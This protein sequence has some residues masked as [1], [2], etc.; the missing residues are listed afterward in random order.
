MKKMAAILVGFCCY[1]MSLA[2][3]RPIDRIVA[4]VNDG[5]ITQSQVDDRMRVVKLNLS[6][7][8]TPLPSDDILAQQI[9]QQLINI[10]LQLDLAKQ[11]GI[12]V[13]DG[14]VSQTI[15]DIAQNNQ[16]SV[17]N[18]YQSITSRG[19]DY[20]KFRKE[21]AE[22]LTL[23]HL[24]QR[25]IAARITVSDQEVD[26][27]LRSEA[28]KAANDSEYRVENILIALPETPNPDAI[29]KAQALA[30]K[31]LADVHDGKDFRA[32]AVVNSN[33]EQA[34]QGGDLGFRKL[35]QLPTA[36]A[37]EITHMKV[38][39]VVGPI[40]TGNGFHLIKLAE[41]RTV[42]AVDK[43]EV[44]EYQIQQI[45]LKIDARQSTT[46]IKA[47]LQEIR[48]LALM[49]NN[50]SSLAKTNTQDD[51]GGESRWV[52][53][54]DLPPIFVEAIARLSPNDISL[55]FT[56]GN[57]VYLVRLLDK[58]FIEKTEQ[59]IAETKELIFQRKFEESIQNWLVQ[60]RQ[61]SYINIISQNPIIATSSS[62]ENGLPETAT[63]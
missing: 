2:D 33:A 53:P 17:E 34:L 43:P 27:Y 25:D 11:T 23:R 58:H 52:N 61:N 32:L 62:T 30:E 29:K 54:S 9:L 7:S 39:D 42:G 63:T 35:A 40:R 31:L 36:F 26:D 12:R 20:E 47:R 51:Y 8:N 19:E 1:C 45:M 10:S 48:N 4:I 57:A 6:Q 15:A 13:S 41:V 21:I 38:G 18:L 49:N 37:T 22:E 56:V 3:P 60:L 59:R 28:A 46:E 24:R 44:Q 5:I 16:M 55:P 50:F 14:E